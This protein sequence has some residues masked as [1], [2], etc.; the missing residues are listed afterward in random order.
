MNPLK[1]V[2]VGVYKGVNRVLGSKPAQAQAL[3]RSLKPS[4]VQQ[5]GA[6]AV[7]NTSSPTGMFKSRYSDLK[8]EIDSI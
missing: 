6:G 3:Q 5:V 2:A 7:S 1:K 4:G 8:K